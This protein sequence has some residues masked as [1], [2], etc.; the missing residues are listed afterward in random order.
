MNDNEKNAF[1][2]KHTMITKGI[3]II[4]LLVHHLFYGDN[5][6]N[7]N[8]NTISNNYEL[9]KEIVDFCK[10]CIAGFAFLTAFGMT[11]I[12]KTIKNNSEQNF[13]Y[14][15]VKRLLKLEMTVVLIYVLAVFYKRFVMIE[16]IR[17]VYL[18][19]ME[20]KNE[21][22]RLLLYMCIDMFGMADYAETP[23]INYTWWYLSYAVLLIIAMPFIYKAYEKFRHLLLPIAC[24]LPCV[25]LKSSV[26]FSLLLPSA[27]LGTAFSYENWFEKIG[28]SRKKQIN[29]LLHIFIGFVVLYL[30][31]II[32]AYVNIDFS[33]TLAFCIPYIAYSLIAYIPVLRECLWFIGKNATNIFLIHTFIYYYF[34]KDFVYSFHNS[35]SILLVLL[36]LCLGVSVIIECIKKGLHY[37]Q[38]SNRMLKCVEYWCNPK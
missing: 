27:V 21:Y 7:Y 28:A 4:M 15:C 35:W 5:I 8:I 29:V 23:T 31:F 24:L 20:D 17:E 18:N 32:C 1:S 26:S 13:F 34:Y 19:G 11:Y 12:F 36:A 38:I 22:I 10:I 37:D 25:I 14:I 3:L 33:Y 9:I 6:I 2:R 30:S 16:S